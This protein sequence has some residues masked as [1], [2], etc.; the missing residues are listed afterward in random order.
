M[1]PRLLAQGVG[2]GPNNTPRGPGP[3]PTG[4]FKP[5]KADAMLSLL[6]HHCAYWSC[7]E[8][9]QII[10]IKVIW[11]LPMVWE[12][13]TYSSQTAEL[14]SWGCPFVN[15]ASG[16]GTTL[17][18]RSKCF[19]MFETDGKDWWLREKVAFHITIKLQIKDSNLDRWNEMQ[20]L[21]EESCS[22]CKSKYC[23]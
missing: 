18:A 17:R 12:G 23:L 4:S 8:T 16:W 15:T 10:K 21:V 14:V 1:H 5:F 3:L 22:N 2:E 13:G 11:F 9:V 20:Q 19:S 6:S 7:C